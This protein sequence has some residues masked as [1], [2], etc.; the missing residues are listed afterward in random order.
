MINMS[1]AP[2]A[3]V[4]AT[5]SSAVTKSVNIAESNKRKRQTLFGLYAHY[6][7]LM[8]GTFYTLMGFALLV[9]GVFGYSPS[10]VYDNPRNF[11]FL[12]AIIGM[13]AAISGFLVVLYEVRFGKTRLAVTRV[14]WRGIVYFIIALPGFVALPTG[15][16]GGT[17]LVPAFV[18]MYSAYLGEYYLPPLPPKAPAK[19]E[20]AAAE[21]ISRWEQV[22]LA[23][24][25]K[26]PDR[27]V[28]RLVFLTCFVVGNLAAGIAHALYAYDLIQDTKDWNEQNRLNPT[29]PPTPDRDFHTYWLLPAKFFGNILNFNF[30]FIL[31]PVS[32]SLMRWLVDNSRHRTW[33]AY[34]LRALL[35]FLPVDDALKIHKL[36]AYVGFVA[37][38]GH[39]VSH[40]LN[41][42]QKATLVWDTYGVGIWVTGITLVM[43]IFI[44][45]PATQVTVKRGHFEIF[46]ITHMLYIVLFIMALIHGKGMIGPNYWKWLIVPGLVYFLERVHREY[47]TRQPVNVISVTFMSNQVISLVVEKSGALAQYS[48]G[49]YA[50]LCC[51]ALSGFQWHPFTISSAPQEQHVSFHIR[52]QGRGSWTH[53]LREFFRVLAAGSPKACLKLA[54]LEDGSVVPGLVHG[55]TGIP[56]LRIHGPYSAPTQHFSDY[57][58]VLV[59]ASGIGVTPLASALKSIVHFRWRYA[60]DRAFPD[61]AVFVWVVAHKEIPSFRW[62]VRTIREAE[63]AMAELTAKSD[64]GTR[65]LKIKIFITS[66][67]KAETE[68]FLRQTAE[69]RSADDTG[70]WGLPYHATQGGIAQTSKLSWTESDLYAAMMNPS[71]GTVTL[72]NTAVTLGR[73][74]WD[75]IFGGIQ[76]ETTE[77]DVAVTFCGNPRIGSDLKEKCLTYTRKDNRRVTWH[78]HKEVF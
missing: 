28:G 66:H 46:W 39:V 6:G 68:K 1:A 8:S 53:A 45:Y 3:T 34:P 31:I 65:Q 43:V 21:D 37:A 51:P 59:C 35:W 52:V 62:L 44:L 60:I 30:T 61:K 63:Q 49:Q 26:N 16:A 50:Y 56:L 4:P 20:D 41:Y 23:I 38:V 55:P 54:H 10:P 7:A 19:G 9:W 40:L 5:V 29:I 25:G 64:A 69:E 67:S 32:H 11:S 72:S 57:N 77:S 22:K 70:L 73:P 15:I 17:L 13:W 12:D 71:K 27:Q 75:E 47:T 33:Y 78:L 76:A 48:E 58:H 18:N 36:C 42:V 14:P 74:N 2:A 24:G